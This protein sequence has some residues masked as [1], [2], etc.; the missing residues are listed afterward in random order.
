LSRLN[1]E[2]VA[3]AEVMPRFGVDGNTEGNQQAEGQ[4]A[5]HPGQS[6]SHEPTQGAYEQPPSQGVA[7]FKTNQ[8]GGIMGHP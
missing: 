4:S 6:V 1:G 8:I 3:L 5:A 7:A 2:V